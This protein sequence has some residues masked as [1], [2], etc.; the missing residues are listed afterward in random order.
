MATTYDIGDRPTATVTF[1]DTAD[2]LTSPTTVVFVVRTP[3]GVETPYT[4]PHAA[5]TTV[6]TGVFAFTFPAPLNEAGAWHVRAKGTAG[7]EAAA[8]LSFQVRRSNF[9]TP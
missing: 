1:R 2:V 7:L 5:I 8:E 6:S 9:A 3:A 4:S